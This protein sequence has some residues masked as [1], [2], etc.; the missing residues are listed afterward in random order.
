MIEVSATTPG[1][2][3]EAGSAGVLVHCVD[4]RTG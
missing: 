1:A 3:S 4:G 2:G